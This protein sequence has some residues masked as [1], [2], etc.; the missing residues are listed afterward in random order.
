MN[1]ILAFVTN[2]IGAN[3]RTTIIGWAVILEGLGGALTAT[4]V[5]VRYSLDGNAE[6]ISD[7]GNLADAWKTVAIGTAFLFTRDSKVTSERSGAV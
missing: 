3:W 2:L 5:F 7:F 4:S 1:A 6:T